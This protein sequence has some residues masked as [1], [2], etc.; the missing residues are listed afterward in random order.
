MN[1]K[2]KSMTILILCR[3]KQAAGVAT[4][5]QKFIRGFDTLGHKVLFLQLDTDFSYLE[6]AH[7]KIQVL[8]VAEFIHSRREI[9][10]AFCITDEFLWYSLFLRKILKTS[11]KIFATVIHP[12]HY[13]YQLGDGSKPAEA[14]LV[15]SKLFPS[16]NGLIFMNEQCKRAHE[17]YYKQTFPDALVLPVPV[18][19]QN[20]A[21]IEREPKPGKIVSVGR[22]VNFKNHHHTLITELLP[23]FHSGHKIEYWIYGDGPEYPALEQFIEESGASAFCFLKGKFPYSEFSNILSDAKL[24]IGMGTSAIEAASLGLP[25]IIPIESR[26]DAVTYGFF[27]S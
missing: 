20:L 7:G 25:T 2:D 17:E 3:I 8:S 24:F 21:T 16:D 11:T 14:K 27:W 26:Q 10:V 6:Q 23:Y 22:L 13:C 5:V 1:A 4:I 9:D 15:Q 18:V 12:R 19:D